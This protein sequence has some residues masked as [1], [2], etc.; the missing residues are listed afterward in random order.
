MRVFLF[1]LA[2]SVLATIILWNFGLG[3]KIWPAHPLL[4]ST[5]LASIMG[6]VVQLLLSGD[7]AVQK[8]K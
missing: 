7:S 2:A 8:S 5:I 6:T 1:T 4:A 3:A